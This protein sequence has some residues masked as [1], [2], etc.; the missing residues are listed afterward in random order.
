MS[1]KREHIGSTAVPGLAAKPI[2]DSDVSP[3]KWKSAV[4]A[5][6]IS[7]SCFAFTRICTQRAATR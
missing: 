7:T 4:F 6:P 3:R 2:I 1:G 5:N